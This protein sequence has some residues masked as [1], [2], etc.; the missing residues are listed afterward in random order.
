MI[1]ATLD[2]LALPPNALLFPET[3]IPLE[4]VRFVTTEPA[5]GITVGVGLMLHNLIL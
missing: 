5:A 4:C 2:E 3:D 1:Q